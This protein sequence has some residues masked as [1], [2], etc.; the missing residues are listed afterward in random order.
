M[1]R[2]AGATEC[3]PWA[4]LGLAVSVPLNGTVA[5]LWSAAPGQESGAI[6]GGFEGGRID[7]GNPD[8]P[9]FDCDPKPVCSRCFWT[10]AAARVRPWPRQSDSGVQK[11]P[12]R[13]PR[14]KLQ[15]S[16]RRA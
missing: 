11:G 14:M 13:S 12:Q 10:E 4:A 7:D 16:R 2:L 5:L 1:I 3:A 9:A 15:L 8:P 6:L